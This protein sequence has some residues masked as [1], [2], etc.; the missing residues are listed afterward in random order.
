MGRK[1]KDTEKND[2][3]PT[4]PRDHA[5]ERRV[6]ADIDYEC[7]VCSG[8]IGAGSCFFGCTPCDYS[9]CNA[10]YIKVATGELKLEK[11][12]DQSDLPADCITGARIDP[13]ITELCEHFNVEDRIM[14][15]LNEVMKDRHTTFSSDIEKLWDEL[16]NAR[17]PAGLLMAKIK[18]IQEGVFVGKVK[19]PAP[20]QRVIDRY[21][22]DNDART[23]LTGFIC[24]RPET[25]EGDL[26]EIERRCETSGN[27]SATVMMC[28]VKLH[29]G[30]E[31]PPPLRGTPHRDFEDIAGAGG[32][33]GGSG[34]KGGGR[35]ARGDRERDRE[36][37]RDR[38][39]GGDRGGGDRRDP[40]GGD[41]DR[42]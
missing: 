36:R 8:D 3:A 41:G 17:S 37:D 16:T 28:I 29:K 20:V 11:K 13:D 15:K 30:E 14:L 33:K 9:L 10:C 39:R 18:Q 4:C 27:P 26:Y 7:D 24:A 5:L 38:E 1:K 19:A 25:Q 32:G 22:L 34:G 35:D 2:D 21:R 40:R 23:K 6:D 42:E 31:L 12:A